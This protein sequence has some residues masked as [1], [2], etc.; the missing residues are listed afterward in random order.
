M[1]RRPVPGADPILFPE[2]RTAGFDADRAGVYVTRG[3][4]LA[5]AVIR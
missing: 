1:P 5:P 3:R 4:D 2:R